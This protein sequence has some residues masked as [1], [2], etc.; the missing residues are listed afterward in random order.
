MRAKSFHGGFNRLELVGP[1]VTMG[2][3]SHKQPIYA[4]APIRRG[5]TW[6]AG[7]EYGPP[8]AVT[9]YSINRLTGNLTL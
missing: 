9:A 7:N 5:S 2:D 4:L 3:S 1:V 8:G 6:Y